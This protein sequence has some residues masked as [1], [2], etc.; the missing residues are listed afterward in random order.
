MI[1]K[2]QCNSYM[3]HIDILNRLLEIEHAHVA[4]RLGFT[5]EAPPIIDKSLAIESIG[6]IDYLSRIDNEKSRKEVV[7]I[8][9]LLWTYKNQEW[10]EGLKDILIL[11]LSRAGFAPSARMV[12]DD[13]SSETNTYSS[14]GS[15]FNQYAVALHHFKYEIIVANKAY[16]VTKFQKNVWQKLETDSILGISAPTSAGKSFIILLKAIELLHSTNTTIVYIVPTLSLISQVYNDFKNKLREFQLENVRIYTNIDVEVSESA[17]KVFILTQEKAISAFSYDSS[18][19]LNTKMLIADEIQNIERVANEGDM[20]SKVLYDT[21]IEF[22]HNVNN[23]ITILSGPRI[24]SLKKLG[25]DIFG[26]GQIVDEEKT[27]D[28]PVASITYAI[29]KHGNSYFFDQYCE[30]IEKPRKIKITKS[31]NLNWYGKSIYQNDYY[32][33]LSSFVCRINSNST[34]IIFAPTSD[35]AVDIASEISKNRA[36]KGNDDLISL[37]QYIK[38][39]VNSQY[40][41]S[42]YIKK[43]VAYH[44]GKMPMHIRAAIEYAVQEKLIDDIACT[45]TLMQGVN[46]PVQNIVIRTP[47][48]KIKKDKNGE[49]PQLTNY[50]IANLRGRAGRLLKDFIG[51]TYILD[52]SSFKPDENTQTLFPETEK[53]L[54]A[55]YGAQ[56]KS[57]K[58]NID[59]FLFDGKAV[60]KTLE[61]SSD[62]LVTY[63][64]YTILRYREQAVHKLN[65]V[66]IHINENELL[67]IMEVL[68]SLEVSKE[69]C[70][71]NRYWDPMIINE[72]YLKRDDFS[73]PTGIASKNISKGIKQSVSIIKTDYPLYYEKHWRDTNIQEWAIYQVLENWVKEKTLSSIFS[74]DY[75]RSSSNVERSLELIQTNISYNIPALL[76]PIYDIK[77]PESTF[78]RFIEMGAYNPITRRLIELNIPRE[79]AIFLFQ[80]YFKEWNQCNFKDADILEKLSSEVS[81]INKWMAI[82][83]RNIL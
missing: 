70:L 13:F 74:G 72:I 51:R 52:S 10:I 73:I 15:L 19:F 49:K 80:T 60:N 68:D 29:S 14:M 41:L 39:T 54:S 22:R 55:G 30:P 76:K 79:I 83:I 26:E 64:R 18:I 65:S 1:L 56:Y 6:I 58:K 21:L 66:G 62:Y 45:T 75:Y 53:E 8:A 77:E 81:S 2:P 44:H 69:V 42:D 67:L 47:F 16:T 12:D 34:N 5:S 46:L 36:L 59:K 63:I 20:R 35:K 61:K 32:N 27:K 57:N 78:L 9:A 48:L 50:E 43:G 11:V 33:F 24:D 71:K 3:T 7:T 38:N 37:S 31:D 4:Y 17:N 40:S 82:Q 23:P 25:A 28:S